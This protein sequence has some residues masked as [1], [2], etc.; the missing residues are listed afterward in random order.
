[1]VGITG[2]S[3]YDLKVVIYRKFLQHP[4][5]PHH[6]PIGDRLQN[7][8]FWSKCGKVSSGNPPAFTKPAQTV[9]NSYPRAYLVG[10]RV[11]EVSHQRRESRPRRDQLEGRILPPTYPSKPT[12][13]NKLDQRGRVRLN[14]RMEVKIHGPDPVEKARNGKGADFVLCET[15]EQKRQVAHYA[16]YWLKWNGSRYATTFCEELRGFQYYEI[17]KLYGYETWEDFVWSE[18]SQTAEEIE[19]KIMSYS[20]LPPKTLV[21]SLATHGGDR[22]SE[23]REKAE[24]PK[25]YGTGSDYLR[26]RLTRDRPDLLADLESGKF[27][28]LRQACVAA[29]IVK[30]KT[31]VEKAADLIR[32]MT[33]EEREEFLRLD[34]WDGRAE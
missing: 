29:G 22:K 34:I 25:S 9:R 31:R 12:L 32:K 2:K 3:F 27:K 10:Q 6:L 1:M 30:E 23:N 20:K 24:S 5:D 13:S 7:R 33:E 4:P 17:H 16:I 18:F 26:R 14:G 11:S 19:E 21:P 15:E 8:G 28:S